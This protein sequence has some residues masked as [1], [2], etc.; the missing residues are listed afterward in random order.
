MANIGLET[1]ATSIKMLI[2]GYINKYND[3]RAFYYI[4]NAPTENKNV[5]FIPFPGYNNITASGATIDISKND[6]TLNKTPTFNDKYQHEPG[7]DLFTEY[8]FMV[9][10]L[11]SFTNYR[12]KLVM[13]STNQAYVPIINDIR[14]IALA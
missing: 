8:E 10:N 2:T 6:G 11:P 1:P 4:E 14:V 13:T 7:L 5:I 12:I 9:D 3:I